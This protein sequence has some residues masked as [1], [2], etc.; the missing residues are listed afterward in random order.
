MSAMLSGA[1]RS[2]AI[3]IATRSRLSEKQG[4]TLAK[5]VDRLVKVGAG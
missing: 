2:F 5:L 4:D 1:E 3:S